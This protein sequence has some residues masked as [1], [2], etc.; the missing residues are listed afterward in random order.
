ME[1]TKDLYPKQLTAEEEAAEAEVQAAKLK[2]EDAKTE[3]SESG[4]E[5]SDKT[6]NYLCQR[7]VK[8]VA[9]FSSTF[10]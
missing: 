4:E 7:Q 3:K 6:N 1:V 9:A 8:T 2:E 10:D 5:N